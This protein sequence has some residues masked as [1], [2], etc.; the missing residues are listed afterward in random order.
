VDP[1][2]NSGW[3]AVQGIWKPIEAK[4]PNSDFVPGEMLLHPTDLVDF[5]GK[6]K[7]SAPEFVSKDAIGLTAI[8][9][10]NSDKLGKGYEN[11]LFVGNVHL[12]TIFHFDLNK[13][14]TGLNLED[15]LKDKIADNIQETQNITFAK[16]LGSITDLKVGP[17]GYLY[18]LSNYKS[19]A[20]IFVIE[21]NVN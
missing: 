16:G 18:V 1:G 9:F 19:K 21:P 12:G 11:D 2:F 8:K 10:L 17:D 5:G 15:A 3:I 20:S 14:R 13:N 6:G 7:Y 4:D